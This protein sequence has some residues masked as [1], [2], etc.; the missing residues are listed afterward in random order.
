MDDHIT[1]FV[2]E[3]C[4]QMVRF[5]NP[6]CIPICLHFENVRPR[7][8]PPPPL[9]LYIPPLSRGFNCR[10]GLPVPASSPPPPAAKL[11]S[12]NWL[13]IQPQ[14]PKDTY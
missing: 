5:Y 10:E 2:K 8:P 1:Y 4:P 12:A 3:Y 14:N 6:Y 7:S 13:K 11:V 9:H